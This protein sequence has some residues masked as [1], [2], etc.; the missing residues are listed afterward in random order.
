MF[1]APKMQ[2]GAPYVIE[3]MCVIATPTSVINVALDVGY[4][5]PGH[6]AKLFSIETGLAPQ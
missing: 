5:N 3:M 2:L 6:F 1:G 4:T